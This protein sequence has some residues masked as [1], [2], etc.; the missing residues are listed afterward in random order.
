MPPEGVTPGLRLV[1]LAVLALALPGCFS[2]PTGPTPSCGGP[3]ERIR[4]ESLPDGVVGQPYIFHFEHNCSGTYILPGTGWDVSGDLPPGI[5]LGPATDPGRLS[6]TPTVPG[7]FSFE[8]TLTLYF[9][10]PTV[11]ETKTFS[12]VVRPAP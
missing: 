1:L 3:V 2:I 5:L 6:G 4:T 9:L 10:G 7:T 8:I 11:I 12:L